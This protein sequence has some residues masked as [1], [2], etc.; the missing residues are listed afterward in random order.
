MGW[1]GSGWVQENG[2]YRPAGP[3]DAALT[4]AFLA[5]S[6]TGGTVGA[7]VDATHLAAYRALLNGLVAD[8]I[9][10]NFD[11]LWITATQSIGSDGLDVAR[12]NLIQNAY[13]LSGTAP[14]FVADRG[15]TTDGTN[16]AP[17]SP[18]F[19]P[20][21]VSGTSK[22]Q[23]NDAMLFIWG[24]GAGASA[25]DM[26][27]DNGGPTTCLGMSSGQVRF[28]INGGNIASYTSATPSGAG[29]LLGTRT[30]STTINAFWAAP[31]AGAVTSLG[32]AT[33]NSTSLTTGSLN[34]GVLEGQ[35]YSNRQLSAGGIG[36]SMSSGDVTKFYL[37]LQAFMTAVG[38]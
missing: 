32:A 2:W 37:R 1:N 7:V 5:R 4:T 36:K 16:N 38:N 19:V 6:V 33:V 26:G 11:A 14:T 10:G 8:G 31:N 12:L 24:N 23:L 34:F 22:Y 30:S 20:S 3:S 29:L 35:N 17:L 21:T 15:T 18:S 13:N 9:D 28:T 25:T 27:W